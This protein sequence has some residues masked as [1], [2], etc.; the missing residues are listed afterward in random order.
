[1]NFNAKNEQKLY[2]NTFLI[3]V[4][5]IFVAIYIYS[6]RNIDDK[7]APVDKFITHIMYYR[8]HREYEQ[9]TS[10]FVCPPIEVK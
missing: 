7:S 10:Q 2:T 8:W 4:H 5:S 6:F 9:N 1:M 3:F